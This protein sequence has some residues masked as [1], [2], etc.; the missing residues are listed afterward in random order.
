MVGRRV[1]T[2][3]ADELILAHRG[4]CIGRAFLPFAAAYQRLSGR[5]IAPDERS[6]TMVYRNVGAR[7]ARTREV[8]I[9]PEVVPA[10]R[11]LIAGLGDAGAPQS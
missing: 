3:G 10:I 2:S 4:L 7:A 11:R 8:V 9:T 6:M 5:V 1:V